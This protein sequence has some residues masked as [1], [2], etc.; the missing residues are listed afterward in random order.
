MKL[1][2]P[3][4][5]GRGL[6]RC[7]DRALNH[8]TTDPILI[9]LLLVLLTGCSILHPITAM[10]G[11]VLCL[12]IMNFARSAQAMRWAKWRPLL[13][14]ITIS[15]VI[16]VQTARES[17]PGETTTRLRVTFVGDSTEYL[18]FDALDA[19]IGIGSRVLG[20]V[21]MSGGHI[22]SLVIAPAPIA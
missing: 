6:A 11:M 7:S 9:A 4:D 21:K 1:G 12:L 16:R 2:D 8:L 14:P 3:Y 22:R 5:K 13:Q 15:D 17:K 18:V 10:V 19:R 20:D